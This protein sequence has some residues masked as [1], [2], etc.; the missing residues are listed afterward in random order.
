MNKQTDQW[1]PSIDALLDG[2]LSKS[3]TTALRQAAEKDARLAT[4]IIDA[5]QVQD[6]LES[7]GVEQAPQSLQKRLRAI[8]AENKK[9]RPPAFHWIAA[10]ATAMVLLLTIGLVQ[11]NSGPSE[12][13][14]A[15]ARKDFALAMSYVSEV[16]RQTDSNIHEEISGTLRSAL[17]RGPQ[18]SAGNQQQ[19]T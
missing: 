15:Q 1:Q 7:L 17:S 12:A 9:S 18:Q 8:P 10:T 2:S 16:S 6:A 3:E 5:Y 4:A 11:Q 19:T 14:I 13:E